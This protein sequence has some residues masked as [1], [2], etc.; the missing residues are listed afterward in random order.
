MGQI[1]R[2]PAEL[3]E[4]VLQRIKDEGITAAQAARDHG[5]P[6]PTV[7]SWLSANAEMPSNILQINK[8]RREN[9]ELKM[10]LAQVLL[11]GERSKKN[12]A[13]HGF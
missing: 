5:I 12:Q 10:L 11:D 7:Y 6:K 1:R 4:Q 2:F 3:K 9:A 13:R 8:L